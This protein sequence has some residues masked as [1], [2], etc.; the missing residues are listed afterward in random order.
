MLACRNPMVAAPFHNT[1]LRNFPK[2][3]GRQRRGRA[4]VDHTLAGVG[5][6]QALLG[7][8][9]GH[10]AQPPLLLHFLRVADGAHSWEQPVLKANEEHMGEFQSL[11]RVHG[12]HHHGV[13]V[14][15][16]LL[17]IGI[18]GDFFQKSRQSGR[19][20]VFHIGI[21]AGF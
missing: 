7:S 10:V 9:D 21:D 20:R 11:G 16:V 4:P 6:G 1:L 2:E 8:C 19:F 18:Q 17:Q 15:V 12:H 14:F 3:P 13:V 5:D